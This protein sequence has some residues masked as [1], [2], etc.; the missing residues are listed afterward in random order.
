MLETIISHVL[1]TKFTSDFTSKS[2]KKKGKN[3]GISRREM[4]VASVVI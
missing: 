3:T 4:T 1:A 2:L